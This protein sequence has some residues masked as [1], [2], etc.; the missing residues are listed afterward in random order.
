MIWFLSSC[1]LRYHIP[2]LSDMS[3]T[4]VRVML[5]L[6]MLFRLPSR[7]QAIA[8]QPQAT[9]ST[10]YSTD[11]KAA[12][13]PTLFAR[14][15]RAIVG[16]AQTCGYFDRNE[17]DPYRCSSSSVCAYVFADSNGGGNWG[18]FCCD[19]SVSGCPTVKATTC[20]DYWHDDNL[21]LLVEVTSSGTLFW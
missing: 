18:P 4:H 13:I 3:D 12:P 1:E 21:E 15:E 16:D 11:E 9:T 8:F 7:S 19:P 10:I 2:F 6:L 5:M 20:L 17:N 14:A